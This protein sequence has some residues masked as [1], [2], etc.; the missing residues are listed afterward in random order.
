[1]SYRSLR[2]R[3]SGNGFVVEGD[4]TL[5]GVTRSVTIPLDARLSGGV[6]TVTGSLPI[7]F[8]DYAIE[9]PTPFIVL[10]VADGG[11]MELQLLFTKS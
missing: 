10:S 6:I 1:M 11:T 8:S 5:H 9:K 4:L 3:P 2:V 7:V